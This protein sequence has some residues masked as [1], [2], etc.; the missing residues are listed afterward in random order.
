MNVAAGS[1][2]VP[3]PMRIRRVVRETADVVTLSLDPGARPGGCAFEPG[4]FDMLYAH[5]VGEVPISISGDADD[6]SALVHT[7]RAVG[8]VTRALSALRRG[9]WVGVRGPFGRPW[10]LDEARGRDLVFVAGGLG[11]A[12]LRPAI[13]R[14]L[15]RRDEFGR[16]VVLYGARSPDDMLFGRD[17]A[18]WRGRFDVEVE[19]IVDR[20]SPSWRGKVGVVTKLV[21]V[22]DFDAEGAVAMLCGPEPMMRF[23]ARALE[24]RGLDASR[25]FLSMERSMKC[26][27]GLC[28]HCQWGPGFVCKDG[29]VYALS[30]A[31][32][33]LAT[34]EA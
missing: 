5:G 4:Q 15:A 23:A 18:A 32:P 8:D 25:V 30:R 20:A 2:F 16:V 7:I 33:W 21:D 26:G 34:R 29:P 27:V 11:L 6:P 13:L 3:T 31:R 12:P 17:L 14:A 28:G 9:E 10:P 19:A 24:A 22:G 1:V